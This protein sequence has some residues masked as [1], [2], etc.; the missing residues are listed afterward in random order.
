MARRRSWSRR[1]RVRTA[2]RSESAAQHARAASDG[3]ITFRRDMSVAELLSIAPYSARAQWTFGD[4]RA[5]VGAFDDSA[6]VAARVLPLIRKGVGPSETLAL[7]ADARAKLE[8]RVRATVRRTASARRVRRWNDAGDGYLDVDRYLEG[9]DACWVRTVRGQRRRTV[10]LAISGSMAGS[11]DAADF[12]RIAARAVALAHTLER[13]GHNVAI[14]V[15]SFNQHTSKALVAHRVPIK[16]GV[17]RVDASKLLALTSG[18]AM[19]GWMYA[20]HKADGYSPSELYSV[21]PTRAHLDALGVDMFFGV[22]WTDSGR[23]ELLWDEALATV[24]ARE[25][26]DGA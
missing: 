22:A 8:A 7:F 20:H 13:V 5:D 21:A 14:D 3:P 10:R 6:S 12:G 4:Y 11:H 9:K 19:R 23:E 25:R 26:R 1:A 18:A 15:L 24:A 16:L 17:E 2:D